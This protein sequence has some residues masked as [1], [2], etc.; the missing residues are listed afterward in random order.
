M[1]EKSGFCSLTTE[2]END[3]DGW[4][5][6]YPRPL[7]QRD[8]FMSL[9]GKWELYV[10]IRG[11]TAFVGNITVPYPPESRI[12]GIERAL[13]EDETYVYEK[14]FALEDKVKNERVLLH[15]G[16]VD[17]VARVFVNGYFA[18]EH[19]GGYTPFSFDITE[20]LMEENTLRVEVRDKLD[21][22]LPY[23][24]QRK[25]RGGMWYTPISGIWQ[26]VWLEGVCESYIE[27]IKITADTKSVTIETRG[28]KADKSITIGD[29]EYKYTGDKVTINIENPVLWSPESPHLYDFVLTDGTDRIRSYFAMRT[30][31]AKNGYICLN[32][33]P[34]YFHGVLDQGY[35]SDGIFTP[36]SPKGYEYDILLM[37]KLGFNMLRKHIKIEPQI[38]YHYCD[39]Y[40]MVVFQ[41]AVNNGKYSFIYDTAL[42]TMG[43]RRLWDK[44]AEKRQK[45]AFEKNLWDMVDLLYSH[46]SV[47]YWTIFNE[48]WGQFDAD[49]LYD[50]MK[51]KDPTRI[52]DATS[53]W[54]KKHRS[55]VVSEHVYFKKLKPFKRD[56]KPVVLSEFGGYSCKIEKHSFN[57]EKT[58]GYGKY[59]SMA[60]FENAL[61]ELYSMQVLP[62]VKRGLCASVLTQLSDVE[63]ETNGLVTYDR[64]IVKVNS[65][66]MTEI[67]EK[68]DTTFVE[69]IVENED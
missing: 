42:P 62:C 50:E 18:G 37:K 44:K 39:K 52:C 12:S 26:S 20:Y 24:K 22:S 41:D 43:L 28:G 25:D 49:R 56:K 32:G 21:K 1:E 46:P 55:D 35:Y 33:K 13:D 15:F 47:C 48:G 67:K 68:I 16:A 69:G 10:K 54:F 40:G 38:F 63:D 31:E 17:Q 36:G 14:T 60:D 7:M 5:N 65:V 45:A 6:V 4:K 51:K 58:Y 27:K 19:A 8:S 61:I 2:F 9:C 30:I 64:R 59:E 66:R 34:Y 23:G 3:T 57:E 29:K 53:G 11:K